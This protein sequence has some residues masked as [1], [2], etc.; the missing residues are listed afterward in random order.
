MMDDVEYPDVW[1]FDLL[2]CF[3]VAWI[4]MSMYSIV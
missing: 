4:S 2:F 1:L 3:C